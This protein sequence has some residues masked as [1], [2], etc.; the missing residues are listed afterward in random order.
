MLGISALMLVLGFPIALALVGGSAVYILVEGIPDIIVIQRMIGGLNSFPLLAAPFFIY[1][2][3]LM[4]EAG[5]T[6]RIF[7]FAKAIAG[8]MRGGLGYVNVGASVIFSGMSGAAVA[9]AGGLG[10]IEI[11]AM[12]NAGYDDKF[13][14]GI[15]AASSI[16]GPIIPPSLPL[17][18]YGVAADTS[19][20]RLFVA[21][22]IPGLLMACSLSLMIFW[23]AR[24]RGYQRDCEFSIRN[25]GH[26]FKGAFWAL[27]TPV[28]IIGGIVSGAFTPTEA[29]I[30]A[31]VYVL[32]LGT[33][34]YR[35]LSWEKIKVA[36]L[37]TAEI[38]GVV[39]L[40]VA[41]ATIFGWILTTN[42]VAEQFS[43]LLLDLT[44][45]KILLLLL[46]NLLLF[47][48][49]AFM[50][51]IAAIT[52]MVPVLLPIA[53]AVGMD[54]IHFGIIMI[55]NLMI[56]LLTPPVGM[57]LYVLSRVAKIPFETAVVGT[58]P[59]LAPLVLLL[60]ILTFVPE[61]SLWLPAQIY[62]SP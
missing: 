25:I 26:T 53:V 38:T 58:L 46:I 30:A 39:M 13:S 61:L 45:S 42:R 28:I 10:N 31:V 50:E 48:V 27:L 32:F 1:A 21:G 7:D 62:P 37:E 57:V 59:F 8:W 18:I 49:G 22:L 4:N 2:G 34:I 5:V 44:Q 15:T 20:G 9:D 6:N 56:G 40:I 17:I 41:A 52:I 23:L 35:T 11:Q 51:T 14:V 60:L 16:I 12:R 43:A 55:L 19:V 33:V 3:T 54:P 47:V 24:R 29:A 36:T